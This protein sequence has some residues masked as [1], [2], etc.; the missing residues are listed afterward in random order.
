M[1]LESLKTLLRISGGHCQ[2]EEEKL[3]N[4]HTPTASQL[5]EYSTLRAS[6][7]ERRLVISNIL[8][9]VSTLLLLCTA[10]FSLSL[11]TLLWR[12]CEAASQPRR[13]CGSSIAEAKALGC[14]FDILSKAWLPND[15]TRLGAEEYLKDSRSWNHTGWGIYAD[16]AQ[17]RELTLEQLQ[18]YADSGLKWYG[19]EREHL[20][21]CAWGL[22]RVLDAYAKGK[23]MDVVIQRLGHTYHCVD[24]LYMS[25]V[26][27]NDL[28]VVLG[29]GNIR[30]GH[31]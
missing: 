31:C 23:R 21:H 4:P 3:L 6:R 14:S 2:V 26:K 25:A 9:S 28:D 20:V 13:G 24:R 19:T 17:T 22:K 30:F 5:E 12:S 16:R 29:K 7:A 8:L 18:E 11:Y 1:K 10:T 27:A 15:C